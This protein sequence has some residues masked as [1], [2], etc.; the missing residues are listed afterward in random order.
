M[1]SGLVFMLLM[2]AFISCAQV[3]TYMKQQALSREFYLRVRSWWWMLLILTLFVLLP[4]SMMPLLVGFMAFMGSREIASACQ[5][6]AFTTKVLVI[7]MTLSIL[8]S[9][10]SVD[11]M[12]ITGALGVAITVTS[13][14]WYKD[15]GVLGECNVLT[16]LVS[17]I[18]L[19]AVCL[20]SLIL[21]LNQP[22]SELALSYV[23]YLIFATQFNDAIQYFIGKKFGKRPLCSTISPNKTIEGAV[24]GCV[25]VSLL[26]TVI[27]LCITP[28]SLSVA[29]TI[30]VVLTPLGVLGDVCVSWFKRRVGVKNMGTL[31]PGHGGILDRID[32]LLLATPTFLL[33]V[34]SSILF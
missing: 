7:T 1:S 12:L 14:F 18:I 3:L 15:Q 30:S 2:F 13:L 4:I 16:A 21:L 27:A 25:V 23:L 20:Y 19:L 26:A 33:I 32:S 29:L 11:L 8:M 17:L 24:G 10:W 5:L 22:N 9:Y 34:G 31:I 6:N 28:F